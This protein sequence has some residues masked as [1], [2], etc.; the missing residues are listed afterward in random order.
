MI[1]EVRLLSL[2]AQKTKRHKYHF[3]AWALSPPPP[4]RRDAPPP[5]GPA[6]SSRR[7]RRRRSRGLLGF[8]RQP[9]PAGQE[10]P[11][12]RSRTKR[13]EPSR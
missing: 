11:R 8:Q 3:H 7:R 12:G 13:H 4:P 2:M 10:L 5:P 1:R 9:E 6:G